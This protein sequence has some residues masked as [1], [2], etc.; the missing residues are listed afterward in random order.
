MLYHLEGGLF[1]PEL[2]LFMLHGSSDSLP[3]YTLK[4]DPALPVRFA[5]SLENTISHESGKGVATWTG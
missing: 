5:Q 1:V 4:S 2:V 3:H